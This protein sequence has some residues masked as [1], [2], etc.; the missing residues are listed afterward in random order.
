M[1]LR[2]VCNEVEFRMTNLAQFLDG[3]PNGRHLARELEP[4]IC[5]LAVDF[6]SHFTQ[7]EVLQQ[8][9]RWVD[10]LNFMPPARPDL[11]KDPDAIVYLHY[12]IN[13]VHYYITHRHPDYYQHRA[14]GFVDVGHFNWDHISIYELLRA[15]AEFDLEWLPKPASEVGLV[16]RGGF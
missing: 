5:M 8:V 9:I 16:D 4:F 12:V 3:H 2:S 14:F 6:D 11:T 10:I 13:G 7:E 15:G 1:E